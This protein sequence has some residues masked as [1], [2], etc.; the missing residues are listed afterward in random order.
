MNQTFENQLT[1]RTPQMIA[2]EINYIKDQTR[3]IVLSNSIEI[4]RRLVEAKAMVDHGQWGEWLKQSVDYS[5]RTATNLMR[6]YE[7]YG[8]ASNQQAFANLN[9]SQAVALLGIPQE[10]REE[11]VQSNPVSEMSTR[12]LQQAVKDKE[13]AEKE[14]LDLELKLKAA[15]KKAEEEHTAWQNVSDN[16]KR[17]EEVNHKYY[18]QVE[19]LKKELDAA[20][21]SGNEDEV[22]RLQKSLKKA[23]DELEISDQK[24]KELERE[25]REKPVDVRTATIEVPK[26]PEEVEQ[27]LNALRKK[28]KELEIKADQQKNAEIA[29]FTIYFDTLVKD[30]GSI[31]GSLSEVKETDPEAHDKYKKALQE[32][33]GKMSERL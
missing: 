16:Y 6:I 21:A 19:S 27:E 31:L 4:G 15:E 24:I 32:L 22:E 29:K 20:K 10:E 33:I 8:Q 18:E 23:N 17:L 13:Q 28:N 5:Q 1:I 7:E 25:L 3:K 12:E 9:Y 30:F 14:K 2:I 26:V 11:F